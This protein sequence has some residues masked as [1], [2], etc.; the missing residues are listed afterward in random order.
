MKINNLEIM[1]FGPFKEV[2]KIDFN[3]LS[4]DGLFMLEGPTGSG[5]SSIIDAIVWALYGTTAHQAT[6]RRR[7]AVRQVDRGRFGPRIGEGRREWTRSRVC[8]GDE[9]GAGDGLR[10]AV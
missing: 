10:V 7:T 2:Q 4:V 3:A 5:K 8:A 1:A 6:A 9:R